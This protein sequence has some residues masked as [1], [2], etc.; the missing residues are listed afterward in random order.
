MV[1]AEN[2][3]SMT[4]EPTTIAAP[5]HDVVEDTHYTLQNLAEMGFDQEVLD[6][7]ALMT[8]RKGVPYLEYVAMLKENPIARAVKL[9]DLRHNSDESRPET[10]DENAK[11]RLEKCRAASSCLQRGSFCTL[12]AHAHSCRLW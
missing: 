3:Q 2:N 9:A 7:L 5:L 11:R 1:R 10:V 12:T 6:T 8:H 4:D